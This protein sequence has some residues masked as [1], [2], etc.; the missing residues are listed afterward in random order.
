M[1]STRN[2]NREGLYYTQPAK[3]NEPNFP[4]SSG[5]NHLDNM[6]CIDGTVTPWKRKVNCKYN[7][8]WII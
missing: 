1:T 7:I 2:R 4:R 3:V 8:S 6:A 5:G